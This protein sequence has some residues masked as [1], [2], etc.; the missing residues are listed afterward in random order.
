MLTI[1]IPSA[2]LWDEEA[3]KFKATPEFVLDF[4]HSLVSLSK[5]ESKFE[6][7]F[8]GKG[9]KTR[10]EVFEYLKAMTITPDVDP[11]TYLYMT[12]ENI[13]DIN[14]YVNS[15]QSATT[16]GELPESRNSGEEITSELIYFWMTSYRIPFVCET[17]HLNRL[18]SLLRICGIKNGEQKKMS[19]R[20][21][22]ARNR[23]LNAER[24]AKLK[25]KG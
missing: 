11:D 9:D 21:I 22:L 2:E 8:L 16:F 1:T 5:W 7:P 23:S 24:R 4:E 13:D 18:F 17:W 20:E 10:E 12:K 3:E 14:A 25:T 15:N 19:R 6:K